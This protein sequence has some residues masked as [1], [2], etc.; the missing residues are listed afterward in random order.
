MNVH[1]FMWVSLAS[2]VTVIHINSNAEYEYIV[3]FDIYHLHYGHVKLAMYQAL[4]DSAQK[5]GHY[6]MLL[7]FILF[8]SGLGTVMQALICFERN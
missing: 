8:F 6:A 3:L 2:R 4:A 5:S 1:L 7:C